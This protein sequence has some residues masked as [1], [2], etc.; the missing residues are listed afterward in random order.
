MFFY[1]PV[2][3]RGEREREFVQS[4]IRVNPLGGLMMGL[5][6]DI[7]QQNFSAI[8]TIASVN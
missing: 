1:T 6:N 2:N 8:L 3:L 4:H 5:M 7:S